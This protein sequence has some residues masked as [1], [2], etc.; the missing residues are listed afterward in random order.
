MYIQ[1]C[2]HSS[3]ALKTDCDSR[4]LHNAAHK[5]TRKCGRLTKHT[6]E[7]RS[8]PFRSQHKVLQITS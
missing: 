5:I 1:K 2:V 7:K 6:Q 8:L 4:K 3:C